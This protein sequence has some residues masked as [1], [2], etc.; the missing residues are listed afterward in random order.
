MNNYY[1]E[2]I[3]RNLTELQK[4]FTNQ[5]SQE[6]IPLSDENRP[7]LIQNSA[8]DSSFSESVYIEND[9][10]LSLLLRNEFNLLES[11]SDKEKKE[12]ALLRLNDIL[13]NWMSLV[14]QS[15]GIK[16]D[17]NNVNS[18]SNSA[19][20]L[21]YG[22]YKLGVSTP[23]GDMDTL[24]L[25]P[26]YVDREKHFFGLLYNILEQK[27]KE[28]ENI[29]DLTS[30]NYEHSI[31]PLIK[32]IFYDV[33]VD[34]V[35]ASVEDV[36]ALNGEI[37][38]SGL[39]IRNNLYNDGYLLSVAMDEK[40]QR[41]YNGFRN[42][43]MILN[44]MFS[45]SEK[46]NDLLIEKR[47]YNFRMCLRCLKQIAKS[48]GINE[49]KF[50]YLGGIAYAIM[51]AKIVQMFPNYSFSHLLEKFFY[52]YGFEWDWNNWPVMIVDEVKEPN[53]NSTLGYPRTAISENF[54]AFDYKWNGDKRKAFR[55][56]G[57]QG[58]HQQGPMIK[59]YMNIV[60]P[61]WPQMNSSYN[62]SIS[63]RSVIVN[64]FKKKYNEILSNRAM[65]IQQNEQL[66]YNSWL[67]FYRK[68]EFFKAYDQYIEIV[69]VC[70][71]N[72]A[73][74]LKWKGFIESKIRLLIDKLEQM[75]KY[76]NFE[77][78][79]WPFTLDFNDVKLR[80]VYHERLNNFHLKEKLYIG[81]RVSEDYSESI[82]LTGAISG[83]MNIIQDKW[84]R[85]NKQW[86]HD[87]FDMFIFLID[88]DSIVH[89]SPKVNTMQSIDDQTGF[90]QF[91][92]MSNGININMLKTNSNLSDHEMI[93]PNEMLDQLLD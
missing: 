10:T 52:V 6:N 90:L 25:T 88:Q 73:Q 51:T 65:M 53:Q 93:D 72:D 83:F 2:F 64:I 15:L 48:N 77:I 39:S 18:I 49:N 50:G 8:M 60:T 61:A 45:E 13:K 55:Q 26:K 87:E 62:I 59:R 76:F 20:L 82:D 11:K 5:P 23:T 71:E 78:Q 12:V 80:S 31:T 14:N 21:C 69:I 57:F 75:L 36:S 16:V 19:I 85:E 84:V 38:P 3:L 67:R 33:S 40:M 68:F 41:S 63:T 81:M 1:S 24:V 43:E 35:F 70:K 79:V 91:G 4:R 74:F 42:A 34:M 46:K 58:F 66:M 30:I 29:K 7:F 32:M 37:K 86:N 47:I 22:S 27:A 54:V 28:N 9:A 92:E 44:S 89:D 56:T 17:H